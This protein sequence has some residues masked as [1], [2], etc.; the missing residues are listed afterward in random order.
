MFILCFSPSFILFHRILEM[1]VS[2]FFPEVFFIVV[3]TFFLILAEKNFTAEKK[4]PHSA[5]K[6]FTA[7]SSLLKNFTTHSFSS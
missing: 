3:I 2:S 1:F 7:H 4:F 6:N 5:L